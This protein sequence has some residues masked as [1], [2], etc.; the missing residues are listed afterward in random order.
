LCESFGV[1][2]M[3]HSPYFGPGMMATLQLAAVQKSEPLL[4]RFFGTVEGSLYGSHINAQDGWFAI[5]DG[6]G[7]GADPD[8]DVIREYALDLD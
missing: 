6:P 3:P 8:P 7:L 5:P 4:E 1:A 2:M